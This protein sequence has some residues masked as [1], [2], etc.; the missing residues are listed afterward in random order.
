[1]GARPKG[2][3]P[4]IPRFFFSPTGNFILSSLSGG[5]SR[6]IAAAVQGHNPPQMRVSVGVIFV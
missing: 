6:G 1:M 2:G 4:K 5:S 3:G